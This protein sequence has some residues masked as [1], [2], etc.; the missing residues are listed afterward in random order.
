MTAGAVPTTLNWWFFRMSEVVSLVHQT[1]TVKLWSVRRVDAVKMDFSRERGCLLGAIRPPHNH[2]TTTTHNTPQPTPRPTPQP[3]HPDIPTPSQG[4]LRSHVTAQAT[5]T[6]AAVRLV[7]LLT[8]LVL[9][10][11]KAVSLFSIGSVEPQPRSDKELSS[12]PSE[13]RSRDSTSTH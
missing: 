9:R 2:H 11:V 3:T 6:S 8:S 13:S 1:G 7:L 5:V 12:A 10:D 4:S